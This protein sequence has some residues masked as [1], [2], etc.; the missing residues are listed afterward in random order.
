[1]VR[2]NVGGTIFG[3]AHSCLTQHPLSYFGMIN[4]AQPGADG[5]YFVDRSP[6]VFDL[7][8]AHLRGEAVSQS[9][10]ATERPRLE[11]LLADAR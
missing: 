3:V 11:Q 10:R 8:L 1:V 9:F 7:V 6:V 4:L 5:S 2:L